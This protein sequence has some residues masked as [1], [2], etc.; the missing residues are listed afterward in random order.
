MT[1]SS[2]RVVE[3]FTRRL[4]PDDDTLIE[5]RCVFCGLLIVGGVLHG[6]IEQEIEHQ[7]HCPAKAANA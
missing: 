3:G 2:Q 6:L 4:K 5:S 1:A 7:Q